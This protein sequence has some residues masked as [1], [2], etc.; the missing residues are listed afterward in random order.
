[1]PFIEDDW[2]IFIACCYLASLLALLIGSKW[3][4]VSSRLMSNRFINPFND[5]VVI[6]FNSQVF[7][8]SLYFS[9]IFLSLILGLFGV[10]I[11]LILPLIIIAGSA[12]VSS[13]PTK[14]RWENW[15]R[16]T[17]EEVKR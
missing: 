6:T 13:F 1:V 16:E 15:I 5:T 14:R 4:T 11:I 17:Q 12:L 9:I 7:R 2:T 10:N 8:M 3:K